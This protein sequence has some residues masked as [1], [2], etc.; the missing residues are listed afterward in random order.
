MAKVA[1]I[2]KSA[3]Q[4]NAYSRF[5]E[6]EFDRYSLT[7]KSVQRVLKKDITLDFEAVVD[8]Y[9]LVI[10]VGAEACKFVGKGISVTQYQGHLVQDKFLP[11][12]NPAMISLKPEGKPAF[13]KAVENI[14]AYVRG[15]MRSMSS[16]DIRG[17]K[18][19][20]EAL[21]Y[22]NS[23]N[24]TTIAIDSETSALYP[25]DGYILGVSI[26]HAKH[27]GVYID[28]NVITEDVAEAM[29]KL[30]NRT[31]VVFHNA[32]FDMSWF[33]YHFGWHFPQFEDTMLLHYLLDE[34]PGTH[35][36]KQLAI[37]YTKLGDYDRELEDFK[38]QYCK[39][40]KIKKAE[41]T[42]DLIPFEILWKYAAIDTAATIEL[43]DVFYPIV[44]KSSNLRR[45]YTE[46]L[47][48]GM[49]FLIDMENNGVPFDLSKL[50][51]AEITLSNKI[52][53]AEQEL[54]TYE[55]IQQAEAILGKRF[56]PNSP[57]QLRLLFFEVL[58]LP[59]PDK[60][61]ETGAISTDAEVLT[62][63][64]K[65]H[66]IP[67]LV[68]T[69]RKTRKIK[70]TYI[71]KII[72]AL[73][74]D[75]RLRT[76]FN[77]TS[78][79][80]GRL[81]SS[82]KL[83]MQQLP[84]DDKTVKSCITAREGYK[85]V[86]QDL[87]TAEMYI[88][89]VLSGDK[90]LQKVFTSGGDFHS[91][92]AHMVFKLPCKVE[93]VKD[94]FKQLRQAAKAISF[95]ILYGSG[96]AKV[97]ETAGISIDEAKEHIKTYFGTFKQLAKWLKDNQEFIKA[98]GHTYTFFGRKRRLANVFSPDKS[99]AAGAVRSGVN[100]LVQSTASDVNLL[101]AVDLNRWIKE[102]KFEEKIKVF[103]L[104][105]D[106]ILAEVHDSV[107]DI[108]LAKLKEL[109]QKDRGVSI[110]NC[111]IGVDAEVGQDY[112]FIEITEPFLPREDEEVEDALDDDVE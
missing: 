69:I 105:H 8:K 22:I 97:A 71:D 68:L 91:T 102:Q 21:A 87:A 92:I 99:I 80:S 85:I 54:Y 55:A 81:S 70:S 9:D 6:F 79:T 59:V 84:R 16:L 19:E 35:G 5:F 61:T 41:F 83:N 10:L 3:T 111:P 45:A 66:R 47:K 104:V 112:S 96:P 75:S 42:Y 58:K 74:R 37:K 39:Q 49:L 4:A 27:Q 62:E 25:R 77:L 15:D 52:L 106:S 46:L 93:E 94:K 65:I 17:I 57:A 90:K 20:S 98:Y 60:R 18:S 108:Y 56:N 89:A 110:A 36:L 64:S 53:E 109:T 67:E 44:Q 29:Q 48:P 11:I 101:A 31:T 107:I 50:K 23:I 12:I 43:Y 88:A 103:A 34:T 7:D 100:A 76:S 40:Y 24:S 28:A 51:E 13:D 38:I 82:G 1:I 2:D 73:D 33:R 30:F 95:G 32:K 14:H 26:S 86:S 72:P 78:T 63:L